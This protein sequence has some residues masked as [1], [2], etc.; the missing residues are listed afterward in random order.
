M[1]IMMACAPAFTAVV[2]SI[3]VSGNTAFSSQEIAS[4]LVT[5]PGLPYVPSSLDRDI[6]AIVD[7]YRL[8]GYLAAKVSVQ[9]AVFSAD[10]SVVDIG[11][12]VAEG[13]PSVVGAV[14]YRG[15]VH[16]PPGADATPPSVRSSQPLDRTA[17]E[18][19]MAAILHVYEENGYPFARCAVDSMLL[20]Q[21]G[22][23]DTIDVV[24]TVDEGPYVT[25]DEMRVRGN[26][27]TKQD[28]VTR[29]A[30]LKPGEPYNPERIAAIR[31]RLLKLNIFSSVEQP[32]VYLREGHGGVLLRVAEGMSNSID[33]VIGYVPSSAAGE[34]GY[35]TGLASVSMRN[36]FGTGRKLQVKWQKEDRNSEEMNARYEEPWIMG[37]PINAGAGFYQRQQDT[38]YVQRVTDVQVDVNVIDDM[39]AGLSVSSEQVIP[40]ADSTYKS[41]VPAS[42]MIA[43]GGNLL[44]DTRSDPIAPNGG[45]RYKIAYSF[46]QK[47][48]SAS[49][50]A[51]TEANV[52][53]LQ[54]LKVDLEFY[55][56]IVSRQVGV[57]T[58]HAYDVRG[59]DVAV[60]DMFRFG[61]AATL[62]GYRENQFIASRV[63]WS[64]MEYRFMLDRRSFFFVFLDAGYFSR[65]A[66][67]LLGEGAVQAFK[68]GYGTGIRVETALGNIGVSFALGQGD[69]FST[70]KIHVMV[71]NEF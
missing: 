38:N 23:S 34:K 25:I 64:N 12:L 62:R 24:V 10:S 46:G 58:L 21:G 47:H 65:P 7:R 40:S 66:S 3:G 31:S 59:G 30:R 60:S 43:F 35:V 9:E 68:F 63:A 57:L 56:Q 1:M 42:R 41:P 70:A 39:T 37:Q 15:I 4:W 6:A 32:E 28:V 52:S 36:L 26:K 8:N 20:R 13:T 18:Q 45:G 55:T 51:G 67:E 17:L 50:V 14:R 71:F 49:A 5:K 69:S 11:L 16:L 19:D 2:R 48:T 54:R 22:G 44:Y 27:E 61:G 29:E 53:L 33:G